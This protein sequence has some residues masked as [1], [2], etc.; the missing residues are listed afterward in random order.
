MASPTLRDITGMTR[1]PSSI[2]D[3]ALVRG[4]SSALISSLAR[5][6]RSE[7]SRVKLA[8]MVIMMLG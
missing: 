8:R 3:S 2:S 7:N 4:Y 5:R 6:S 1:N